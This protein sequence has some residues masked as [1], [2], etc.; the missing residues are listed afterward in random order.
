MGYDALSTGLRVIESNA[1]QIVLTFRKMTSKFLHYHVDSRATQDW[2]RTVVGVMV[3]PRRAARMRPASPPALTATIIRWTTA[4]TAI[5]G[6]G[7]A[8][9]TTTSRRRTPC[10]LGYAA[11]VLTFPV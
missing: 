8:E 9:A 3:P 4:M 2:K 7:V 6:G 10:S 1:M 11:M 5:P